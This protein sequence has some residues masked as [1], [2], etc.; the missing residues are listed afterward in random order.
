M[1][2]ITTEPYAREMLPQKI[3]PGGPTP[4]GIPKFV[5]SYYADYEKDPKELKLIQSFKFYLFI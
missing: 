2:W 5:K 4:G 1:H 3:A